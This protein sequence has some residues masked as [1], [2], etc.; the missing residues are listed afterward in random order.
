MPYV[1][2]PIFA[3]LHPRVS[4]IW[5]QTGGYIGF[6]PLIL[7]LAALLLPRR[8]AVKLFLTGWIV[9][10]L[11]TT[12]GVPG[13]HQAFMALPLTGYV[14]VFRYL[15]I[16]WIFCF[17]FLCAL[18]IDELAAIARPARQRVLRW[19][20]A[21]AL[22]CV[23]TAAIATEPLLR[24]L[25][26]TERGSA[27]MV[28]ALL[29]VA[30]LSVLVAAASHARDPRHATAALSAILVAEAAVWFL[31]PYLSNALGGKLDTELIAFCSGPSATSA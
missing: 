30:L 23:A 16:T 8:R 20:L 2:G 10:A 25:A 7:A 19:A 13:I 4:L 1:Y 28:G 26:A 15:D 18:L 11:G 21:G 5:S 9:V 12:H 6:A 17:V 22:L 27:F 14:A 29:S 3:S 31:V 24:E